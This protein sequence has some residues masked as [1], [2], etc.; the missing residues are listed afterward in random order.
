[1][2]TDSAK[3]YKILVVDDEDSVIRSYSSVLTTVAESSVDEKLEDLASELFGAS[4][5]EPEVSFTVS[6]CKQGNEA[7]ELVEQSIAMGDDCR[8]AVVFIDMRMPPGIHGLEAANIIHEADP[9]IKIVIVTGYSDLTIDQTKA[10][11]P[12]TANVYYVQKPFEGND[13]W[14]LAS[15]LSKQWGGES[16]T[17]P[18]EQVVLDRYTLQNMAAA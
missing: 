12:S 9:A 6:V 4:N 17:N 1:M 13:I 11:L 15:A 2:N 10:S 18:D 8:F 5:V 16:L 7:V 3:T 14:V